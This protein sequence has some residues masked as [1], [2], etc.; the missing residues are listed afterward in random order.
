M[1]VLGSTIFMLITVHDVMLGQLFI[2]NG[3]MKKDPQN[4]ISIERVN[5]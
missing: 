3:V 1:V 4:I 2:S 5:K